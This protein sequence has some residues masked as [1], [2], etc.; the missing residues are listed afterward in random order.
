MQFACELELPLLVKLG[1]ELCGTFTPYRSFDPGG[2]KSR[3]PITSVQKAGEYL[4]RTRGLWG[5]RIARKA[6]PYVLDNFA[7]VKETETALL[8]S[9]PKHYG[10]FGIPKPVMN[11]QIDFDEGA[12][13]I[14]G[15]AI[16][17]ADMCWPDCKLDVEYDS[18]EYHSLTGDILHDNERANALRHLGYQVIFVT[19]DQQKYSVPFEGLA[20]D[21]ARATGTYLRRS[22][23]EDDSKR[24]ALRCLF[25]Q[26]GSLLVFRDIAP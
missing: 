18:D 24:T 11:M 5:V 4:D 16:A 23:L 6:L 3:E 22:V 13:T 20:K 7:S 19:R 2:A 8:L 1:C 15:T 17:R 12:R 25:E 10:G 9:L 14:A 26:S 21:I